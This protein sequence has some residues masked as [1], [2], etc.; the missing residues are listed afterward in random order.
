MLTFATNYFNSTDL[1]LIAIILVI[2]VVLGFVKNRRG[3]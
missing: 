3:R 1:T 2:I